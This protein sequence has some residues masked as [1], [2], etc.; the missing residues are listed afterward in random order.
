MKYIIIPFCIS[1][2]FFSCSNDDTSELPEC[3]LSIIQNIEEKA[4][5]QS[6]RSN[7]TSFF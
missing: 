6:P 2:I 5:V 3:I 1:L 7:I 4:P